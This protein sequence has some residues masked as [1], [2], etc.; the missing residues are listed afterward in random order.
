MEV[1]RKNKL[2]KEEMTGRIETLAKK[3]REKEVIQLP[4]CFEDKRA[5]PNSFIRSALF[6]A[7]QAKDRA[8]LSGIDI[9]SQD[10]IMVNF[11]VAV[12]SGQPGAAAG[13]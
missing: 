5:T 11:N 9:E 1:K 12:T 10:R 7:V 3:R 6:S 2:T 4:I 13:A 8:F